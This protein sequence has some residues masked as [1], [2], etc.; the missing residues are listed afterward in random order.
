M[1]ILLISGEFQPMQGG[2]G[3]FTRELGLAMADLGAEV[4][5]LTSVRAEPLP[6]GKVTVHP[7]VPRWGWGSLRLALELVRRIEPDW[8]DIQYQTAA[9]GMRP[10]I[11]LL[12]LALRLRRSRAKVAVTFHDLREPYLFPKAGPLRPLATRAL[13]SW[14][15]AA[16]VTN[17]E[18]EEILAGHG[19]HPSRALIPIGS[20]ITPRPPQGY[21]RE[22]RRARLGAGPGEPLVCYFGFLNE[23][24]GGEALV[25]ALVRL[26]EGG[27]PARLVM[28]GGKVGA[29]DPTNAAYA[30]RVEALIEE[31]GL[32]EA[33]HWTGFTGPQEVSANLMAADA[34]LLPYRDGASFR[35]GSFM[36]ALAHGLA[37]VSTRPRVELPELADGENILLAPADDVEALADQTAR[38]LDDLGLRTRLGE[39]ARELS[40][41][42]EWPRI[43][44][45]T[46]ELFE[47]MG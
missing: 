35:R 36:A 34:C 7:V 25:R 15:D 29:S 45:E 21:D 14:S 11:N 30:G 16:I 46:L 40:R 9:Y 8:V 18:D 13:L 33:V 22:A 39:G 24:K 28:V 2:V 6:G 38:I 41:R 37:I 44:G 1:K 42:F 10:A 3:D 4:H 12:P 26:R 17:R 27:R 43:A 19:G 5:V 32:A 47:R 23:S 31:L 20:N